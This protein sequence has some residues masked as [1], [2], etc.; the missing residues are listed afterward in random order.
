MP[1]A[2]RAGLLPGGGEGAEQVQRPRAGAAG[3]GVVSDELPARRVTHVEGLV[4]AGE[5]PA[6]GWLNCLASLVLPRTEWACHRAE[7]AALRSVSA[8]ASAPGRGSSGSMPVALAQVDHRGLGGESSF[9]TGSE[10]AVDGGLTA[11]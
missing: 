11:H 3:L 8:A 2:L 10:L 4:G 1:R 9:V 6:P 7:N 5:R